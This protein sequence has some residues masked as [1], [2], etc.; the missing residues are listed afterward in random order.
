[1]R[2]K[3]RQAIPSSLTHNMKEEWEER[4]G[5]KKEQVSDKSSNLDFLDPTAPQTHKASLLKGW[6]HVPR[7]LECLAY[8]TECVDQ[9]WRPTTV[10]TCFECPP[11]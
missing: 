10:S 7:R 8:W 11:L 6:A 3:G 4:P 2:P 5:I 9:P 1:M